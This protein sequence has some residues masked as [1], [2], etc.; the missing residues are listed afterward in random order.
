MNSYSDANANG[1]NPQQ[2]QMQATSQPTSTQE[3]LV[4]C[5]L[6]NLYFFLFFSS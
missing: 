2:Q 3:T 1:Q 5:T 6:R 4:S